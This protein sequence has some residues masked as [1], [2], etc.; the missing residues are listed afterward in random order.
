MKSSRRSPQRR[1]RSLWPIR[2]EDLAQGQTAGARDGDD[3]LLE[4]GG[5]RVG[6]VLQVGAFGLDAGAVASIMPPGDLVDEGAI[7]HEV[8]E[9]PGYAR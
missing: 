4:V 6:K 3:D 1:T 8:V 2:R 5:A 9:V 7:G